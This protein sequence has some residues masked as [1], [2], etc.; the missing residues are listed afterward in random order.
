VSEVI[1]KTHCNTCRSAFVADRVSDENLGLFTFARSYGG[2]MHPSK[3][4][5]AA[6][7]V[8]E[9]VFSANKPL[10][11]KMENIEQEITRQ[12]LEAVS[13]SFVFPECH[14]AVKTTMQKYVRL[15]INIRA[16]AVNVGN[17]STKRHYG[18]K[19]AMRITLIP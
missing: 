5:L 4:L 12:V 16:G 6:A 7:K 8:A 1:A 9:Q 10:M 11:H 14:N 2:L 18:G 15:R 13:Q 17:A 19:S 3:E